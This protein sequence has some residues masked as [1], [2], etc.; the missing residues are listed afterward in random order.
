MGVYMGFLDK[1]FKPKWKHEDDGVRYQ[2][3]KHKLNNQEAL[4]DI[5]MNDKNQS[6]RFEAV[7]KVNDESVLGNVAKNDSESHIR[8]EAAKKIN[9]ETVL[10][11]IAKNAFDWKVRKT[12]VKKISDED[13]LVDIAMN[14]MRSSIGYIALRRLEQQNPNSTTYII[15]EKVFNV[16]NSFDIA[17]FFTL[18]MS[19][20]FNLLDF[21]ILDRKS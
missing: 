11:D 21:C 17:C 5:A 19:S 12:A 4:I 10:I 9:D 7:K 6:V 13:V 15:P 20:I 16:V 18:G 8:R 1:I 14:N 3:V 2:A